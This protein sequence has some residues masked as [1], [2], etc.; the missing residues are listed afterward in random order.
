ME[1]KELLKKV[2]PLLPTD[3]Y[4]VGGFV[5]DYLLG[6]RAQDIDLTV[7]GNA[8][9]LAQRVAKELGGHLFSFKKE[10]LP[11]GEVYTVVTPY[12]FRLDITPFEGTIEGELSRRDFTINA[13]AWRLEDFLRGEENFIDPFGGREDLKKGLVRAVEFGNLIADPLRLFR[14]YR[15]A[16][17]LNFKIEPATRD[18]ILQN[19]ELLKT[20]PPE[21]VL[22]EFLKALKGENF[23]KLYRLL[24]EDGVLEIL[25]GER[26]ETKHLLELSERL[27]RVLSSDYP[28]NLRRLLNAKGET[29]LGEFP[30]EVLLKVV[31]LLY[32]SP[33]GEWLNRYPFGEKAKKYLRSTLEGVE[34]LKSLPKGVWE[35]YLYLKRF[36]KYLFPI[37]VWAK[38]LDLSEEF[39]QLLNFYGKVYKRYSKPLLDGKEVINLLGIKP[40]PLVGK[41]L[42]ELVKAQLEGKVKTKEQAEEFVKAFKGQ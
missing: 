1:V 18:F 38:A 12:G 31:P 37:G 22:N 29:F 13:I 19:L 26:V 9:E 30:E 39:E 40:S 6:K 36:E 4:L 32:L 14:A 10:N 21:R 25:L 16:H 23:P 35:R 24:G 7:K 28:R 42:E 3:T 11:L 34:I 15:F 17:T 33:K 2:F 41:I 5:R 27:N 20:V 8:K